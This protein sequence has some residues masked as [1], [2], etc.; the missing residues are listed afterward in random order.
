LLTRNAS[1]YSRVLK[2]SRLSTI[3][4]QVGDAPS[5]ALGWLF[6]FGFDFW[7][8]RGYRLRLGFVF[9]FWLNLS[10]RLGLGFVFDFWLD[11]AYDSPQI[12]FLMLK[13]G[14]L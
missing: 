4:L 8:D 5:V 6:G 7:L 9:D 2:I 3:A 10:Y 13:L 12:K 11:C 14:L 1:L